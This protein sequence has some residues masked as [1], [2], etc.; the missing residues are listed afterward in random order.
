MMRINKFLAEA[1]VC[2][3]RGADALIL[4]GV[5]RVNGLP[6]EI[7]AQVD[8]A[9]DRVEVNGVRVA[10]PKSRPCCLMLNKPARVVSTARDP[11]GRQ[12]V[13]DLVPEA[14]ARG[15]RLYPVG[16]L[17]YFSEGLILLTDDGELTQRLVHPR[18]HVAKTYRV[19]VRGRVTAAMLR[20]MRGG[21][22]LAE[23]ERLAPVEVSV[24]G[25][26]EGKTRL[27]MTL[28]QGVNR[29]I[30]R[31]MRDLGLTVLR[32]VRVAEGPLELGSLP[33]GAVRPLSPEE[34]RAL[35]L[36]AGLEG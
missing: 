34:L 15:R 27:E 17:D 7:G 20:T 33:A 31:M 11:E 23:G 28:R 26:R 5:V 12:T 35:R 22:T 32:L 13:L 4:S 25:E 18:H 8:E 10:L 14:L 36:E 21:M 2:S 30:R 9:E 16:R 3:R 6:A 19:L 24:L 1:G 29:Q